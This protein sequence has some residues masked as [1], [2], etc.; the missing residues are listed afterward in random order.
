M[1]DA[2]GLQVEQNSTPRLYFHELVSQYI[3]ANIIVF[4][5]GNTIINTF[6]FVIE[7]MNCSIVSF[8]EIKNNLI[9]RLTFR[10]QILPVTLIL[11]P[12]FESQRK[13]L[14]T[15]FFVVSSFPVSGS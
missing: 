13:L 1:Q 10:S 9:Q 15:P 4:N 5:G 12:G 14:Q 2:S 11:S 8:S 7:R 6:L 3:N